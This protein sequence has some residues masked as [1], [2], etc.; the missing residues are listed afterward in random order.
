MPVATTAYSIHKLACPLVNVLFVRGYGFLV[1]L[2]RVIR[3]RLAFLTPRHAPPCGFVVGI[4]DHLLVPE[5]VDFAAFPSHGSNFS[6]VH[7]H[8][9]HAI[10]ASAKCWP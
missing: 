2:R 3:L 9:E 7:S 8:A 6:H 4:S 1:L 5:D 10:V